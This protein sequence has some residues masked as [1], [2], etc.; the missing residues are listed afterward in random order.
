MERLLKL[1][2]VPTAVCCVSD[3][4]AVG[5]MQAIR[6]A[7]LRPGR[8]ISVIGY[9]GL[10][11]GAWLDPPLTTMRQPLQSAG[12]ML[13]DMLIKLVEGESKPCDSQEL[14]RASLVRRGT[15]NPP[16]EDWPEGPALDRQSKTGNSGGVPS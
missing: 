14:F 15:A 10:D 9:D 5:A 7:G 12:R 1:D 2:T 6:E 8:E 3:V 11:L 4:V 13:A 16:V